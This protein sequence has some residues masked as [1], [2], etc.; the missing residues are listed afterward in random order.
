MISNFIDD[1]LLL[2]FQPRFLDLLD[3][4]S[5]RD[6]VSN[7]TGK[8]KSKK[9]NSPF[10]SDA[11]SNHDQSQKESI[12]IPSTFL[13]EEYPTDFAQANP[14]CSICGKHVSK[15]SNFVVFHSQQR[16]KKYLLHDFCVKGHDGRHL[17][18][19]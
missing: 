18:L 4:T 10:H 14:F 2:M 6:Y 3:T 16:R 17:N 11:Y 13:K 15:M 5:E 1:N 12:K 8:T 7:Q 9:Q 19:T